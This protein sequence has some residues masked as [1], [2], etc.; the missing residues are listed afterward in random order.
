MWEE[1]QQQHHH[2]QQSRSCLVLAAGSSSRQ[3]PVTSRGAPAHFPPIHARE[4]RLIPHEHPE[5]PLAACGTTIPIFHLRHLAG[6]RI[7]GKLAWS[8]QQA[9]P[10]IL[11]DC[12]GSDKVRASLHFFFLFP[13]S[14]L[15]QRCGFQTR[16]ATQNETKG[17]VNQ[18]KCSGVKKK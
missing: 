8:E 3:P 4:P 13:S 12:E 1:Q 14:P 16:K 17:F 10:R 7:Q 11:C 15:V 5:Q 18:S 6:A 2:R 9:E